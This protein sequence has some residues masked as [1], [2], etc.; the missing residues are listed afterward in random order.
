MLVTLVGFP[1]DNPRSNSKPW[2]H[3]THDIA[4]EISSTCRE[5]GLTARKHRWGTFT[6]LA[7]GVSYGGGQLVCVS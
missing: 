7:T 6:A 3:A 1:K 2:R 5:E 4:H